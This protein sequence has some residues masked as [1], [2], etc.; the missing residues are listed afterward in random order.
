MHIS[1]LLNLDSLAPPR[2]SSCKAAVRKQGL[3][4]VIFIARNRTCDSPDP[5]A[6][7]KATTNYATLPTINAATPSSSLLASI[8]IVTP[9]LALNAIRTMAATLLPVT[10]LPYSLSVCVELERA[11][12]VPSSGWRQ[13]VLMSCSVASAMG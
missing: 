4:I 5:T 13:R 12:S 10:V 6:K 3:S 7:L 1:F 8:F 11:I 9:V 2:P